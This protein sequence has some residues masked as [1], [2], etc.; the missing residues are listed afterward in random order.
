MIEV[1]GYFAFFWLFLFS[2]RFRALQREE[3]KN[4]DWL[5]RFFM[6]TEAIISTAFGVV[7]PLA[8]IWE[9]I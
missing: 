8:L 6:V 9:F 1:I 2:K 4:G 5:T 3:W 7:L